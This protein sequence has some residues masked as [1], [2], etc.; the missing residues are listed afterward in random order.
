MATVEEIDPAEGKAIKEKIRSDINPGA[1][2][3]HNKGRPKQAPYASTKNDD[4]LDRAAT[5]L[6]NCSKENRASLSCI[7]RN[8]QNRAA[9]NEFF[10]AY[11][12]CR[13]E[14]NEQRKA[15]N[16]KAYVDGKGSGWF[17]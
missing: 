8:Y 13:K 1:G 15:A 14:E 9:C 5:F 2:L 12:D 6:T 10:Q 7:E 16:A 3:T 17:W 4:P 11:K